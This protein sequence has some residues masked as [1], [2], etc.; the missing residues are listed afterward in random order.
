MKRV[1]EPPAETDGLRILVDRLW[2]RGLSREKAAVDY[3]F[4]ALAPS[5]T[6]RRWYDHDP[7]K[8]PLFR[9]RYLDELRDPLPDELCQLQHWLTEGRPVTLLFGSRERTCNN[10]VALKG[11]FD[12]GLLF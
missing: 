4:K 3:W 5:D 6:L 8:W 2:P 12:E 1:Y 10:A 11:F 7:E 9:T